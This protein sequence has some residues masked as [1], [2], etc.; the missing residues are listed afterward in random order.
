MEIYFDT[1]Y[2]R[3]EYSAAHHVL[4]AT[5]KVTPTSAEF[6]TGMMTMLSAIEHFKTGRLVYDATHSGAILEEDRTWAAT[7]WQALAIA[8]GHSK[9]AFLL[10]DDVFTNMTMED[11]M[12]KA[13]KHVSF[14]YFSRKEDAIQWVSIP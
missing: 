3:I 2:K 9:V 4:I 14:A 13:D 5:W 1:D 11:I 7:E 8:A 10:P 12:E 6:R